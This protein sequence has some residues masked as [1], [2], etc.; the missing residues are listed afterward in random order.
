MG[1]SESTPPTHTH[2]HQKQPGVEAARQQGAEGWEER[3]GGEGVHQLQ[4]APRAWRRPS[5]APKDGPWITR[6]T[7]WGCVG[8]G[9]AV[10]F[11]L[12]LWILPETWLEESG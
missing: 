11:L 10:I 7:P 9:F 2:T 8:P 4:A 5:Y 6:P 3:G 1:G 12:T